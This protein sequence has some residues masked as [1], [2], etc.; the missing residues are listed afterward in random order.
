MM[1]VFNTDSEYCE[2]VGD[3]GYSLMGPW[4]LS[5]RKCGP[6]PLYDFLHLSL[7]V[8]PLIDVYAQC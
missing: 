2:R 7:L 4:A 1:I 8:G 5:G 6:N 3:D